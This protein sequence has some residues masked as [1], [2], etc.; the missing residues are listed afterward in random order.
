MNRRVSGLNL[1]PF[2][3]PRLGVSGATSV[4][5][6]LQFVMR[7]G[8]RSKFLIRVLPPL[9]SEPR[10]KKK[11]TARLTEEG[12][13]NPR[14]IN[15]R[16]CNGITQRDHYAKGP[17]RKRTTAK[18]QADQFPPDCPSETGAPSGIEENSRFPL[19]LVAS[20]HELPVTAR[21]LTARRRPGP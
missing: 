11:A 12:R 2:R 14:G 3:F 19:P 18:G 10:P 6:F 15:P 20:P 16:G 17:L 7:L 9:L 5:G 21:R 4:I 1:L 8:H 13:S